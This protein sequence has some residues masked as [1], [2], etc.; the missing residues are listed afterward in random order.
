MMGYINWKEGESAY[1][2]LKGYEE[3]L[4]ET[5]LPESLSEAFDVDWLKETTASYSPPYDLEALKNLGFDH[6]LE[7]PTHSWRAETGI[8]LIHEEPT[9]KELDRIWQNWQQMSLQQKATSDQKAIEFFGKTNEQFYRH[10]K[11]GSTYSA[12]GVENRPVD[13]VESER[14]LQDNALISQASTEGVIMLPK[15]IVELANKLDDAGL[16][17]QA[18]L[19]DRLVVESQL[20][21]QQSAPMLATNPVSSAETPVANTADPIRQ[22]SIYYGVLTKVTGLGFATIDYYLEI[23]PQV[24]A[25]K[26]TLDAA[27]AFEKGSPKQMQAQRNVINQ[28]NQLDPY[29]IHH[30]AEKIAFVL[31]LGKIANIVK[32]NLSKFD[33]PEFADDAVIDRFAETLK[34]RGILAEFSKLKRAL[35]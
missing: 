12:E 14:T 35:S 21:E 8:E 32:S 9:E 33:Q 15:R 1:Q 16:V 4:K 34:E 17:V 28:Y 18:K 13:S 6:L 3:K 24:E 31:E 30:P 27:S 7:D 26:A 23:L 10:L 20:M 25:I 5:K 22:K 29:N 19:M 11:N 2:Y